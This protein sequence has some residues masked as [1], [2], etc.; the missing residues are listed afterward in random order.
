MT[1]VTVCV[2]AY[3][4]EAFIHHTLASIQ[5]QSFEDFKVLVGVEPADAQGTIAACEPI[6]A[7]HRFQLTVN[8]RVLGYAGNVRALLRR[9]RTPLFAVLPH[10]DAW[11]PDFLERLRQALSSRPDAIGAYPDLFCFAPDGVGA[12]VVSPVV[13]DS[14]LPQRIMS[15]LVNGASGN[16]WHALTR[17]AA[18]GKAF[19]R[20]RHSDFAVEC[21]W[22]LHLLG[23]GPLVHFGEP[24]YLKR[25]PSL[26]SPNS[27]STAWVRNGQGLPAAID[28]HRRR[29]IQLLP[30]DT[31][32]NQREAATAALEAAILRR[33]MEFADGRWGLTGTQLA[34]A[35]AL[36]NRALPPASDM[37]G[38]MRANVRW[39]LSRH[40]D[41][42]GDAGAAEG[43]A[44]D[45]LLDVPNHPELSIQLAWLLLARDEVNDALQVGLQTSRVHPDDP[46]V[47][48]LLE[49]CE[50]RLLHQLQPTSPAREPRS[51]VLERPVTSASFA[52]ANCTGGVTLAHRMQHP[53]AA[54]IDA[55]ESRAVRAESNAESLAAQLDGAERAR[56]SR[57]ASLAEA[58]VRIAI[59]ASALLGRRRWSGPL[60]R[61]SRRGRWF[62]V[63]AG[64]PNPLFDA[65][66]YRASYPD[67]PRSWL[68]A[69]IHWRR[70]GW[71]NRRMPNPLFDTDWY[72]TTNPDVKASRSDPLAHYFLHGSREGRDPSP[73]F[74]AAAYPDRYEDVRAAGMEPLLHYLRHGIAEGRTARPR[75]RHA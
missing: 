50:E 64:A 29:L 37:E 62:L 54:R 60:G 18:L 49:S 66:W 30:Q 67:V 22:V 5:A 48:L 24:L 21:E 16:A 46:H 11:H 51:S 27:V 7:D 34:T 57:D 20:N 38:A 19:P 1:E 43:H 59:L 28:H 39:A 25:Q 63:R 52:M 9:V 65:F 58:E 12:G 10:D 40:W 33:R 44:R 71:R 45:G 8:D 3:R 31:P 23:V 47:R 36:L 55:A 41:A 74:D 61:W 69:W 15:W 26:A 2:P 56:A 68:R 73:G 35:D 4:A 42:L 53:G 13:D 17:A 32:S 70:V 6:L 75:L 14:E 72:L